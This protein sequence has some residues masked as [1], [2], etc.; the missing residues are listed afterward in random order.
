MVQYVKTVE[1]VSMEEQKK[2]KIETK[3]LILSGR[4]ILMQLPKE[5]Q[6]LLEIIKEYGIATSV[7]I[8]FEMECRGYIINKNVLIKKL[9]NIEKHSPFEGYGYVKMVRSHPCV[10]I[11]GESLEHIK[12]MMPEARKL[13]GYYNIPT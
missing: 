3:V 11:M 1:E 5:K 12:M 4:G 6:E 9:K 13:I 10:V 2:E 8:G 7:S